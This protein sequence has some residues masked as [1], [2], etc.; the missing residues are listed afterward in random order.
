MIFFPLLFVIWHCHLIL[1]QCLQNFIVKPYYRRREK[2][3]K[4]ENIEKT[5][6]QV[7]T[8]LCFPSLWITCGSCLLYF[9]F[10]PYWRK[11]RKN[12]FRRMMVY[13]SDN[14][15]DSFPC[16]A[17]TCMQAHLEEGLLGKKRNHLWKSA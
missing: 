16:G 10:F 4:L 1:D 14:S 13:L 12:R 8:C 3:K 7:W 17:V 5:S 15:R 2:Q 11:E 6:A 9:Q